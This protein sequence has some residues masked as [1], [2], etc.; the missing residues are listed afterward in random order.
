METFWIGFAS[1]T[2]QFIGGNLTLLWWI[3]GIF[4]AFFCL[5]TL[6]LALKFFAN[7]ARPR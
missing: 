3:S 5:L 6:V 2:I 7:S 4:L 1:D